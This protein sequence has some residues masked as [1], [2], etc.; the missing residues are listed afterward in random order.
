MDKTIRVQ[1][2][3][4]YR[5]AIIKLTDTAGTSGNRLKIVV[6]PAKY[7]TYFTYILLKLLKY[8]VLWSVF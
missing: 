3:I 4:L 1:M 5:R 7:S 6:E 8:G 2:R